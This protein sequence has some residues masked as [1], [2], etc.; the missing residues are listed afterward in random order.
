MRSDDPD[1]SC[2]G[3]VSPKLCLKLPVLFVREPLLVRPPT[4]V[5][6]RL[7]SKFGTICTSVKRQLLPRY[8]PTYEAS[9]NSHRIRHF[10]RWELHRII[11]NAP[12]VSINHL[13][14]LRSSAQMYTQHI[15]SKRILNLDCVIGTPQLGTWRV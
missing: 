7:L 5:S 8:G 6:P 15:Q 2:L 12:L 1:R 13:F 3:M 10:V 4:A 14:I 9:I 11:L